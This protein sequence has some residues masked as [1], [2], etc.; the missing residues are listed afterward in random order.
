MAEGRQEGEAQL[1]LLQIKRR[2]DVLPADLV[3]K[4]SALSIPEL[5]SLA[6]TIFDFDQI[7][8]AQAWLDQC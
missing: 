4:V 8:N 7:E 5:E 6:E 1:I 3:A 2:F